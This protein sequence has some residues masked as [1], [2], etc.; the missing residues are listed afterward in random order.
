MLDTTAFY[1]ACRRVLKAPG[2]MTI[3]LFGDHDSF[4]KNIVRICEAF[5]DRVLVFPEVH[6]GNVIA[7]AFNGPP[8]DIDWESLDQRARV[9]QEATGLPAR[10][11]VKGLRRANARQEARLRI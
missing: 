10:Q 1:K 2:V 3:N 4:P 8:I 9:V 11:W 6:D 5:D 7:L